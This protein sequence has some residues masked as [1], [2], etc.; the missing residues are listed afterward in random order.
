[1]SGMDMMKE[2]HD[3][4]ISIKV[5]VISAHGTIETAVKFMKAGALDFIEK[6]FSP[7]EIRQLV[8]KYI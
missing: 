7:N 8:A 6:P 4:G 5:V 1:M 2:I 3:L